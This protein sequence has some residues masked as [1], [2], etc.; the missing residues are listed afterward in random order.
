MD[1][2]KLPGNTPKKYLIL[3]LFGFA[4][5]SNIYEDGKTVSTLGIYL[6]SLSL[7]LQLVNYGCGPIVA[8]HLILQIKLYWNTAMPIHLYIICG[9]FHAPIA[10]LSSCNRDHLAHKVERIYYITLYTKSLP[11]PGLAH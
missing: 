10:E 4:V 7:M 1:P 5:H 3:F 6:Y 8:H 9:C 11:T 2:K